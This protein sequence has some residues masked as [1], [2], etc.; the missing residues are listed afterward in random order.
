VRIDSGT[1]A[2][3]WVWQTYWPSVDFPWPGAPRNQRERCARTKQICRGAADTRRRDKPH[4]LLGRPDPLSRHV[5]EQVG[6][7]LPVNVDLAELHPVVF[8]PL[9]RGDPSDEFAERVPAGRLEV[10]GD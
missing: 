4:G 1:N 6:H 8:A 2:A 7:V 9:R 5:D 3:R 10:L